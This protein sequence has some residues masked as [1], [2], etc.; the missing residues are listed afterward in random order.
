MHRYLICA[1]S[2]PSSYLRH[3]NCTSTS[4]LHESLSTWRHELSVSTVRFHKL[5]VALLPL[6]LHRHHLECLRDLF[7]V[8]L[9]H[10]IPIILPD[11]VPLLHHDLD[12]LREVHLHER[13]REV[14]AILFHLRDLATVHLLL[15]N[16]ATKIVLVLVHVLFRVLAIL[17]LIHA[18]TLQH[19]I[20]R[21]LSIWYSRED[22]PKL[23]HFGTLPSFGERCRL[24]GR[25]PPGPLPW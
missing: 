23:R 4:P 17:L 22:R 9:H 20:F 21:G 13:L 2:S 15:R 12:L 14:S 3:R 1:A 25:T 16:L 11:F 5:L 18:T 24:L 8:L 7:L 10:L 19:L 6:E